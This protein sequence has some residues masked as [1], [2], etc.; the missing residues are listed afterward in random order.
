MILNQA[1][2]ILLGKGGVVKL[3]DFGVAGQFTM[4]CLR[5]NSFVGVCIPTNI[6]D[7]LLDGPRDH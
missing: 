5:R 1:A 3:C 2:N 6:V 4:S 7:S